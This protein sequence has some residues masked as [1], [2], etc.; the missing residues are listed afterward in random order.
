MICSRML[1]R[2]KD[3]RWNDCVWM[4]IRMLEKFIRIYNLTHIDFSSSISQ[5]ISSSIF[6][7]YTIL[8]YL[9]VVLFHIWNHNLAMIA[10]IKFM[11]GVWFVLIIIHASPPPTHT[12]YIYIYKHTFG[13]RMLLSCWLPNLFDGSNQTIYM[14]VIS[15]LSTWLIIVCPFMFYI[16]LPNSIW[17]HLQIVLLCMIIHSIF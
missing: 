14:R 9:S 17:F 7:K 6:Q 12:I 3:V 11:T 1:Q 4:W 16:W 8:L 15:C 5:P 13:C 10:A 2:V